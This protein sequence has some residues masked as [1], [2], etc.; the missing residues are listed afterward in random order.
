MSELVGTNDS[1]EEELKAVEKLRAQGKPERAKQR[2]ANLAAESPNPVERAEVAA[3]QALIL[4]DEAKQVVATNGR[5][6]FVQSRYVE[7][8]RLLENAIDVLETHGELDKKARCLHN[9]AYS[10]YRL[11]LVSPALECDEL[12]GRALDV[13]T[14]AHDHNSRFGNLCR[15]PKNQWLMSKII[16]ARG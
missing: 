15:M 6:A 16:A 2:L 1:F 8:A 5:A 7:A 3:Q 12:L 4:K 14:E 9:L 10:L 13:V 11:A